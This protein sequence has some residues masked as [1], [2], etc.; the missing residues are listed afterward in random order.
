MSVLVEDH[1]I[2]KRVKVFFED[3]RPIN[4]DS[5]LKLILTKS[6]ELHR[7]IASVFSILILVRIINYL[8]YDYFLVSKV[9][10]HIDIFLDFI[11]ELLD[12]N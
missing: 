6:I 1:Q 4:N 12:L 2:I 11:A 3:D 5:I 10:I 7:M 9:V 8:N